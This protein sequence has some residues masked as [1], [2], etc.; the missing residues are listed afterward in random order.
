MNNQQARHN[1]YTNGQ[2]CLELLCG[3][4]AGLMLVVAFYVG[5]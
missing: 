3:S 4:L 5:V 2:F 1:V